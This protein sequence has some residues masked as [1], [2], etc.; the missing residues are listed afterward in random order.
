MPGWRQEWDTAE[1]GSRDQV[2]SLRIELGAGREDGRGVGEREDRLGITAEEEGLQNALRKATHYR[3]QPTCKQDCSK[4]EVVNWGWPGW[5]DVIF[6][7]EQ[8]R[9][10]G[11]QWT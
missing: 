4:A 1:R 8:N 11:E 10:K 5:V 6:R 3:S 9:P 7:D 2:A